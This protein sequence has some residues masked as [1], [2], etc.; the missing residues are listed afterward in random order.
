MDCAHRI[1]VY[2]SKNQ[3]KVVVAG[4]LYVQRVCLFGRET[5]AGRRIVQRNFGIGFI[6]LHGFRLKQLCGLGFI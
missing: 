2:T 1:L 5:E 4:V 3:L 6:R